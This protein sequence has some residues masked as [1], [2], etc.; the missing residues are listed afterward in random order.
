[1]DAPAAALLPARDGTATTPSGPTTR[2]ARRDAPPH[3]GGA[4][5][6]LGAL[7]D[8]VARP[9]V[10]AVV[11]LVCYLGAAALNNPRGFLGTDTGAKVATL[12]VMQSRHSFVPD[13]ATGPRPTTRPVRCTRSTTRGTS[14]ATT[15]RSRRSR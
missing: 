10:A 6:T 2:G 9:L 4:G 7:R 13:A 3:A 8:L 1:M 12:Q 15:S 11:L 5:P 14:A